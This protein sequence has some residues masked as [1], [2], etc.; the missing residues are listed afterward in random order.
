MVS[1]AH[2]RLLL[3]PVEDGHLQLEASRRRHG[4]VDVDA[5]HVTALAK[6]CR[7]GVG[8]IYAVPVVHRVYRFFVL[9]DNKMR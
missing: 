1:K 7:G 5:D 8:G 3:H 2:S 4:A 6:P 9:R